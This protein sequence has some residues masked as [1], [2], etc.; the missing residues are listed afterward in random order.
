VSA[1][2]ELYARA[3][4]VIP[5][6]VN[7][8]VRAF[9][10]VG[11]TPVF[12]ARGSGSKVYDVDGREYIDF[13]QSWGALILG[14]ADPRVVAA[15]QKAAEDGTSFGAPTAAEVEL[16][17][18]VCALVPSVERLRL[19]SS[20]TEAAMTAIRLARAA[21]G[22]SRIVKFAGNY[23]GH[24]DALLA[25]GGSGI[26]TFGIPAT[27]GVPDD[28]AA[29]TIV[30]PYNDLDTLR[31]TFASAGDTVACV[32]LE[33]VAANM[34]VVPPAPGFLSGLRESCDANGALLIFDEVITG[35]RLGLGGAQARYGVTPHLTVLAKALASGFP[36]SAV[37]GSADVMSVAHSDGPVRHIGTYNANPISVAAANATLA[38]LESGGD[39][40]YR[41][42]D[43]RAA[44]LAQGLRDAAA[45]AGA[46]LVV[47]QVGA[48][49]HL[50]WAP[51]MPLRSHDDAYASDTA[52]V[53][54]VAAHLLGSG[55]FA[56]ERGLWFI[57]TAHTDEDVELTV[58]AAEHAIA[59]VV[60]RG[61][62]SPLAT[63]PRR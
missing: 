51:R 30:L 41:D 61:S 17:K 14:H 7:S 21:T 12:L 48:V 29:G 5:G 3:R 54:D 63:A 31:E 35:F 6:G 56:L 38:E 50:L 20:G 9:G 43:G 58:A 22:R 4:S 15:V 55:V 24:S 60:K 18:R 28:V 1:S 10:A 34:G 39:E 46:P 23:H 59:D 16:A 40:L 49:L 53:G 52:S 44:R 11:G 36:L 42:L 2:D 57:S 8:P 37:V 25:S 45:A 62:G 19:V 13:V 27:P 47:N 33:P 26:A 32:I